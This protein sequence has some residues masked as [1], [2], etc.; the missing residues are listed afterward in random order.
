MIGTK[1]LID[2]STRAWRFER[3]IQLL[4]AF[5]GRSVMNNVIWIVGAVVI[6]I[7]ILGFFGLS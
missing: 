6:V 2:R 7:A 5:E 1:W 4:S 3:D